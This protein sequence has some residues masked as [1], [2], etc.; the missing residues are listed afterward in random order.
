MAVSR[1]LKIDAG[2]NPA[3]SSVSQE[4]RDD[5]CYRNDL[6]GVSV[7]YPADAG[8][9]GRSAGRCSQSDDA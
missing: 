5:S 6:R 8:K 7:V 2:E 9:S 4:T 3:T 1:T